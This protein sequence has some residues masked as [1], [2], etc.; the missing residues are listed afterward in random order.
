MMTWQTASRSTYTWLI[1]PS[2]PGRTGS[3]PAVL[4]LDHPSPCGANSSR[5]AELSL[6]LP[7]L[8]GQQSGKLGMIPRKT[9]K[10][11]SWMIHHRHRSLSIQTGMDWSNSGCSSGNWGF[12]GREKMTLPVLQN[13][14][15]LTLP[16]NQTQC[17]LLHTGRQKWPQQ[18]HFAAELSCQGRCKVDTSHP[19]WI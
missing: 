2:S 6:S 16:C 8:C 10:H 9:H 13:R 18:M 15:M 7:Q 1:Y 5:K 3:H 14:K 17:Q 4:S 12:M 19:P 11:T